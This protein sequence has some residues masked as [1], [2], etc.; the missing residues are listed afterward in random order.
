MAAPLKVGR[1]SS[2]AD[3]SRPRAGGS[4]AFHES[5]IVSFSIDAARINESRNHLDDFEAAYAFVDAEIE[6]RWRSESS[7]AKTR[8]ILIPHNRIFR[9]VIL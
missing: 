4:G 1:S 9:K 2:A 5:A 8:S 3:D 6:F 7:V